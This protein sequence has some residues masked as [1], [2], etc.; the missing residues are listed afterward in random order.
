MP[1]ATV[2]DVKNLP[3][4]CLLPESFG[5]EKLDFLH[6]NNSKNVSELAFS[7]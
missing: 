7:G 3:W 4:I 6:I 2:V 1:A 5:K